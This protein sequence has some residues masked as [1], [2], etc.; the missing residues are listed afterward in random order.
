MD[1]LNEIFTKQ[2]DDAD[3]DAVA[4]QIETIDI[5][6]RTLSVMNVDLRQRLA[7]R[8]DFRAK[9]MVGRNTQARNSELNKKTG[10][11]NRDS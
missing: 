4:E 7:S 11:G 3:S 8:A 5:K 2:F 9:S 10:D 1:A 6:T